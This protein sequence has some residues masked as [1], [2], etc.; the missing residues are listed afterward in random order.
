[1]LVD[2]VAPVQRRENAASI[3]VELIWWMCTGAPAAIVV[4][5]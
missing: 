3:W 4:L 5:S 2:G 1:L